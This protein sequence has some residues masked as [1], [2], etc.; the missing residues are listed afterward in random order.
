MI[1]SIFAKLL[2]SYVVII[3][4]TTLTMGSMM[5]YLIRSQAVE[6][7][8]IELLQKGSAV[9]SMLYSVIQSGRMPRDNLEIVSRLIGA[10]SW[11]MDTE[12]KVL[13]GRA[14]EHWKDILPEETEKLQTLFDGAP[15]SWLLSERRRPDP[16]VIV[17]IPIPQTSPPVALFMQAPIIGINRAAQAIENLMFYALLVGTATAFLVG[18]I[19]SR[20]LTRPIK[21]IIQNALSFAKGNFSTRTLATGEDEIGQLGRSFNSMAANLEQAET[22]RREFLANVS[23]E[24]KTPV[25]SIQALAESLADGMVT[26]QQTQQRYL[27]NIVGE[28][29]RM[30]H[31]I[32]DLLDLSQLEA[33]EMRVFLEPIHLEE[34]LTREI[35]QFSLLFAEK[36]IEIKFPPQQKVPPVFADPYRLSQVVSNLLSNTCRYA[37][38]SPSLDIALSAKGDKVLIA[39]TDHGPGIPADDLP[40]IFDRFYR[41]EKSR[42]RA[43]GGTGLGLAICKKLMSFMNGDIEVTSS[44]GTGTT[45]RLILPEAKTK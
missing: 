38:S 40:H 16:S 9:A 32:Q 15:Q 2:V 19:F 39:F 27:Q 25:A 10:N 14:P 42:V 35:E 11:L 44:E 36:Q 6:N 13:A 22:N 17:A 4:I 8:R 37:A 12:G 3:L 18:F 45:F 5:S 7:R 29:E 26:D 21:D 23:H 34:F 31:L 43:S 20:S 41:V 24:L 1:R 28:T 33:G 30:G